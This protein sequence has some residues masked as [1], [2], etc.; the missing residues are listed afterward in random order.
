[1]LI[2]QYCENATLIFVTH[3]PEELPS[4]ITNILTL[5]EGKSV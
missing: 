4:C 1:M 3:Y 5:D 2:D